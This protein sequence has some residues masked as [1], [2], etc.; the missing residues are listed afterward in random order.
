MSSVSQPTQ[1]C[2]LLP[3]FLKMRKLYSIKAFSVMTVGMLQ[4]P[5]DLL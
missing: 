4:L 2:Q 5:N 3:M 1:G